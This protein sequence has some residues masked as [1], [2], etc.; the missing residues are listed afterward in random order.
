MK[1]RR[2]KKREHPGQKQLSCWVA[3]DVADRLAAYVTGLKGRQQRLVVEA[4]IEQ[5]LARP[6]PAE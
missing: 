3:A 4:A 5:Y 1:Q 2:G 6:A